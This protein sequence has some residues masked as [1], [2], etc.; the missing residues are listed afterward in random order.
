MLVKKGFTP[1]HPP[2]MMRKEAYEG[3]TPLD[4]FQD[5]LYKIEGEDLHLIATSEHPLTAMHMNETI[6]A[7]KLPL[8]YA[9][10]S[11]CFRKEAGAHG[12]DQKGIFRVHQ[13]DKV[14]Q[15]VFCKPE[16]SWKW[17]EKLLKNAEEFVQ[18]LGIPY[19]VVLL[20][21]GD[22]GQVSAKTY[23]IETW[24]P[25]QNTYRELISCSNCTTWQSAALNM[26]YQKGEERDYV[27]TL[28]STMVANPR[29]IVAIIENFQTKDGRIE[30]PKAL[31]KYT[32]FK[33]IKPK[34]L[35]TKKK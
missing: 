14:E 22:I 24:M 19:R 21:S 8:T 33:E 10:I 20:C 11:P 18:A 35:K 12:K 13:F 27:H 29:A 6:P 3:V 31:H 30:I 5:T 15:V 17:H 4:T 34:T 16:D 2:Y 1:V 7:E 26:R 32:G 9:G 28:N 25:A 23:D